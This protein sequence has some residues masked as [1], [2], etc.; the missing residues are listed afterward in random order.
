M[1]NEVKSELAFAGSLLLV[2]LVVIWDTARSGVPVINVA[3]SP[4][5]FPYIVGGFLT[6]LALIL[7]IQVIGGHIGIP[8]GLEANDPIIKSDFKAFSIVLFSI[9][10]FTLLIQRVGFIIS[11]TLTFFGITYAFGVKDIKKSI[12]IALI[13]SVIVFILF[14][15]LLKVD[16]PAG[17]V[18]FL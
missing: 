11:A 7:I 17:W 18:T 15:D 9:I 2:G 10:L 6:L 13:F 16:L 1:K 8:E 3:V 14:T 12:C 4:K 5:L